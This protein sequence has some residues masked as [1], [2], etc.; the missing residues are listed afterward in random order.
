MFGLSMAD[1]QTPPALDPRV[2]ETLNN[3]TQALLDGVGSLA[4]SVA[5]LPV[6]RSALLLASLRLVRR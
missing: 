5:H 2:I 6:I 1:A 4:A 3:G